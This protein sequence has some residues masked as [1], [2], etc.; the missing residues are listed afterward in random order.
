MVVVVVAVEPTPISQQFSSRMR[1]SLA[2]FV[3]RCCQAGMFSILV[4][5][6]EASDRCAFAWLE[7]FDQPRR[8][9]AVDISDHLSVA[10]WSGFPH[11]VTFQ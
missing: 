11:Q 5:V 7:R 6:C 9:T 2:V 1:R 4:N 8:S 3:R 10:L